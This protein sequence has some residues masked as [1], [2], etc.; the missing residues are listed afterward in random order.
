MN[1]SERVQEVFKRF[2]VNLTVTE[3]PRTDL[4]EATLDNGTVLYTDADD[5]TEG[6]EAYIINDEGERIPLPPGDYTL[7]DGGVIVIADGGK[8]ASVNKGGKEGADGKQPAKG[9]DAPAAEAPAKEAPADPEPSDPPPTKDPVKRTRASEDEKEE[10]VMYVTKDEVEAM[11]AAALE[12]LSPQEE[13]MSSEDPKEEEVKEEMSV[14]PEAPKAEP[15]E[16]PQAEA[17][18]PAAMEVEL[19]AVKAELEAIKKQAADGGLKH[20]APHKTVEPV[21]LKN[22]STSERVSA[23][24]N[25]FSK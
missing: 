16:E 13:E 12:S 5:F 19:A 6:A 22:L 8:V 25:Q 18:E 11:I 24:L 15:T 4:A 20:A 3:E 23:L 14:N 17:E 7:N 10:D 2:N 9:K 21:N 1:I